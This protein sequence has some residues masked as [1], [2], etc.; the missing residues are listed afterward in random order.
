MPNTAM[1]MCIRDRGYTS[2]RCVQLVAEHRQVIVKFLR[3]YR[4]IDLSRD[5]GRVA[6]NTAHAFNGHPLAKSQCSKRMTCEW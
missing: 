3:G 1:E 4:R 2:E 6:Q 5:N